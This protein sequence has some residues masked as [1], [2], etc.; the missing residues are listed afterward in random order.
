VYLYDPV[1]CVPGVQFSPQQLAVLCVFVVSP[2]GLP[3]QVRAWAVPCMCLLRPLQ[4]PVPAGMD[5]GMLI[6]REVLGVCSLMAG[7]LPQ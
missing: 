7:Y 6:S 5:G 1:C 3:W 4:A 2:C